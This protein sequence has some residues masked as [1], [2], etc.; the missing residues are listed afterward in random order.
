MYAPAFLPLSFS[1]CCQIPNRAYCIA[2]VKSSLSPV[3]FQRTDSRK[4]EYWF[5]TCSKIS[6]R[7]ISAKTC[8]KRCK[9]TIRISKKTSPSTNTDFRNISHWHYTLSVEISLCSLSQIASPHPEQPAGVVSHVHPTSTMILS[10]TIHR[11]I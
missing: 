8:F 10:K 2:S 9:D 6:K 5:L 1:T 3:S 4:T 7:L 11:W